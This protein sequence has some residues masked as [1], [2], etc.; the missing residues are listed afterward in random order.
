MQQ[1]VSKLP[2][3]NG[4]SDLQLVSNDTITAVECA[5][6]EIIKTNPTHAKLVV[7]LVVIFYL[8]LNRVMHE[9]GTCYAAFTI[10]LSCWS[11]GIVLYV[12]S[13]GADVSSSVVFT[14][15]PLIRLLS[16]QGGWVPNVSQ[17]SFTLLCRLNSQKMATST[18]SFILNYSKLQNPLVVSEY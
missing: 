18:Q 4:P 6:Y 1:L 16:S 7:T 10:L 5:H 14:L 8:Q 11:S 15:E 9:F 12:A 3:T 17:S 13:S 2:T